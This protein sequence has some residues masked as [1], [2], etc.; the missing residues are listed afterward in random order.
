LPNTSL[1]GKFP[2]VKCFNAESLAVVLAAIKQG[3]TVLNLCA[4][5]NESINTL[6]SETLIG[7][8]KGIAFPTCVSVNNLLCHVSPLASDPEASVALAN[9]DVVRIELGAHIDGYIALV[10]TTVVVGAT[11][12]TAVSGKTANVIAAAKNAFEAAIRTLKPGNTN[13]QVSSIVEKV[14]K[15]FEC[16]PVQGIFG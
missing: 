7:A 3:E 10:G 5:G 2:T 16:V 15:E 11:K 8:K 9:G 4:A 13:S 12:A 14:A 6:C 1:P